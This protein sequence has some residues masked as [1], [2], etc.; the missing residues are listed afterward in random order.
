MPSVATSC[1]SGQYVAGIN[2]NGTPQCA[3]LNNAIR[4]YVNTN[5]FVYYGWRDS[6]GNCTDAPLKFGRVNGLTGCTVTG[7]DSNCVNAN[8]N[9]TSV[10]MV[11]INFDGDVNDDD[12]MYVGL[13]CF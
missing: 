6:C 7:G 13:K 8:L 12:K 11:G 4:D 5:C 2:A 1:P 3:S 9:G 10:T